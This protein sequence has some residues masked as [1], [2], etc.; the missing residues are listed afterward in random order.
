MIRLEDVKLAILFRYYEVVIEGSGDDYI[1]IV[2]LLDGTS[3]QRRLGLAARAAEESE[4]EGLLKSPAPDLG[5]DEPEEYQITNKG[6]RFVELHHSRAQQLWAGFAE[7]STQER[8]Q[9]SSD[10]WKQPDELGEI[11]TSALGEV[12]TLLQR[13]IE[14][15]DEANLSQSDRV[16]AA[17]RVK[18]AQEAIEAPHP[19]WRA[20]VELV[21][22]FTNSFLGELAKQIVSKIFGG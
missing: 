3:L 1:S 14:L 12:R 21:R 17:Q 11:G 7:I 13:C 22:P 20:V 10:A 6:I 19:P 18:A 4:S 2:R 15:I 5:V 16:D 9:L 8:E